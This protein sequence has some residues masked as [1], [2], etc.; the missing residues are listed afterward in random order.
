MNR[1]VRWGALLAAPVA[2]LSLALSAGPARA[3]NSLTWFGKAGD[4]RIFGFFPA[5]GANPTV[6]ILATT[7]SST[8]KYIKVVTKVRSVSSLPPDDGDGVLIRVVMGLGGK[9]YN[10]DV[11]HFAYPNGDYFGLSVKSTAGSMGVECDSCTG[12][13]D[14]RTNTYTEK[15]AFKDIARAAGGSAKFH[16]GT[17]VGGLR[18]EGRAFIGHGLIGGLVP[19]DDEA[20]PKDPNTTFTV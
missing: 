17:V 14:P 1:F 6:N 16:P 3:D 11:S 5:N 7:I 15:V 4:E 10:L 9:E 18:S 12:K 13:V 2:V 19:K 8:G 20:A